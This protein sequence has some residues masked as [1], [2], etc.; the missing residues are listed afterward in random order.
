MSER[1]KRD[2]RR[3][4]TNSQRAQIAARQRQQ[5]NGCA[6]ELA[7]GFHVHHVIP[8][9]QGGPTEVDN[10][11][12]L[13]IECHR[14]APV[15][16][17][18]GFQPR[19]W[20]KDAMGTVVPILRG[21][22]FA[23]VS[24][25]PGAGKTLFA[26][27]T[28]NALRDAGDV[29]RVVVFVP[30]KNLR[31]QWASE[32]TPLNVFLRPDAWR[33]HDRQDGVVLTYHMLQ[34]AEVVEQLI[35][36]AQET[37]T[38]FILDEVHHLAKDRDG[39]SA[40]AFS[41]ASV[42]GS[43]MRPLHPVLNLSGTLFRSKAKERVATIK[44][45]V[46]DDGKIETVADYVIAA[47]D[48]QKAHQLRLLKVLGMGADMKAEAL[49]FTSG[50]VRSIDIDDAGMASKMAAGLVRDEAFIDGVLDET[51]TRLAA[52]SDAL[53]GSAPVKGLIIAD[54]R[55]HADQ[56]YA[57]LVEKVGTRV[58]FV[59]HGPGSGADREIE[60]FRASTGQAIM[61]A[62]QKVSEG[63]DAPDICVLTYL[64]AWKAPLFIN[65]MVGR[66][67]RVTKKERELGLLLPATVIVPD[68]EGIKAA[69]GA[70]MAGMQLLEPDPCRLC[71]QPICACPPVR[72]SDRPVDPKDKQCSECEMP[73]RNCVCECNECGLTPDTG[74][75]CYR[76]RINDP[77]QVSVTVTGDVS[78]LSAQVQDGAGG[79]L[80]DIDMG[81]RE[82]L[83]PEVS[84]A[85]LTVFL[86]E[87]VGLVERNI[88]AD[89][90]FYM[91]R[92]RKKGA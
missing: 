91:D 76:F 46:T 40:W 21:G 18:P 27:A 49:N 14:I 82:R 51:V 38:L 86:E 89:P 81:I 28:Y 5:C 52:A 32:V 10:G 30:N 33:E 41:M 55:V 80:S 45:V 9:S 62:V 75:I 63:F 53:K 2:P 4:F 19:R 57:R 13:C 47:G 39:A 88:E 8:W 72:R 58:A 84:A 78:V 29:N 12:A 25:A 64:K 7:A 15:R 85:G 44:Y 31:S 67:M 60:R 71:E 16:E 11:V 1:I 43:H 24:A 48:L 50:E 20:Q 79:E 22:Q 34:Q 54:D 68:D 83:E 73:W 37:P 77:T 69:F 92:F 74:C 65:Q 35:R 70:V 42:V 26:A 66:A 90:M 36:D 59:A 61:V 23:T 56:V 6:G 3:L 87:I 17:L